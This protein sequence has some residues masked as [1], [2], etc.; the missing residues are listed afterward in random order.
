MSRT[1]LAESL[2]VMFL[3]CVFGYL[4]PKARQKEETTSRARLLMDVIDALDE[5][6]I[7]TDWDG[8]IRVFSKG[9]MNLF[10]V[11]ASTVLGK[12]FFWM[13]DEHVHEYHEKLLS[14]HIFPVDGKIYVLNCHI[15]RWDRTE[16][17]GQIR[18]Q[19]MFFDPKKE[20]YG[21]CVKI[22]ESEKIVELNPPHYPQTPPVPPARKNL[23]KEEL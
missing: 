20:Q 3:L 15:L 8:N 10:R 22:R 5:A 16:F 18:M 9:A 17:D 1:R 6:V 4:Y 14:K 7:V 12:P 11:P 13:L 23:E 19:A 2:F 21:Y